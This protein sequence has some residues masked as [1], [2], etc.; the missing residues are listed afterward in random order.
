MN[1]EHVVTMQRQHWNAFRK[2]GIAL[3]AL[4]AWSNFANSQTWTPLN[5]PPTFSPST[6]LLLTD[7]NV[8]VQ[9]S[10]SGDWWILTPDSSGSY[11]NGT[12]SKAGTMPSGYGPTYYASA[13]LPNRHIVVMGGEYNFGVMDETNLGAVYHEVLNE[14][15]SLGHPSGW[16][17]IGDSPSVVLSNG[18][19]MLGSCCS[20]DQALL[21]D[22]GTS[23]WAST[24]SGKADPNSEEGW[25]LL[26]NGKVLTV[27]TEN[28]MESELYDPATGSWSLAG[29]T[30]VQLGNPCGGDVAEL[31]PAVLRPDGTVFATGGNGHTAIYN[32][33]TGVWTKGPSFPK[34]YG[35][36]DGP[37]ALL[38]NGHVLVGAAPTSSSHCYG[39]GTKY[40]SFDGTKLNP[41]AA[42]PNAKND[43]SYYGRMLVLPSG[44]VLFTDGTSDVEIFTPVGGPNS[45]WLPQI[46]SFPSMITRNK[47][48]VIKGKQFNGL[49]QGAMYGDDSQS[50]TNYPLVQ[51]RNN[52]TGHVFFGTTYNFS[53]MGV[54]TGN[55]IVSATFFVSPGAETGPSTLVVIANGIASSKVNV[56]IN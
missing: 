4:L 23:S 28:G 37:G 5:H 7:G 42:P 20:F 1:Q 51:L 31:G 2:L 29:N 30:V 46:T 35:V 54:A 52:A 9:A 14:W 13:M 10:E 47:A 45:S 16:T 6:E 41:I 36:M 43:K 50:A 24:G 48:Y 49:S 38:P 44:H 33:K 17:Q 8:L 11:R 34:G 21:V 40:F 22:E 32:S 25:T 53:T 56:T 19:F 26:P 3:A 15:T 12:W 18:T 27:D 55:N 39:V